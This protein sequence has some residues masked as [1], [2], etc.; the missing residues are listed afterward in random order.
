[1]TQITFKGKPMHIAGQLPSL[2]TAVPDFVL[3]DGALVDRSLKDFAGKSKL[4]ATVP[5]LDTAV[6]STMTQRL[7]QFAATHPHVLV[8]VVSADLPFAQTRFCSA[9]SVQNVRTLSMMRDKEFG[10]MYGLLIQDG[11]LAGLLARSLWVVDRNNQ[12]LYRE[13]VAEITHE[14]NYEAAFGIV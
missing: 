8:L 7:N 14:P 11:P 5:S 4:I 2:G 3:V 1:M 10:R 13:L 12:L 9:E 6:C